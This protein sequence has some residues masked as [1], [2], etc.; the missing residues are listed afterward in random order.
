MNGIEFKIFVSPA[1]YDLLC[2]EAF[3]IFKR[4]LN[5][6]CIFTHT[7]KDVPKY[8][9]IWFFTFVEFYISLLLHKFDDVLFYILEDVHLD[10]KSIHSSYICKSSVCLK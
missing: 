1:S 9:N 4:M 3:A 10:L 5:Y 6:T 8:K 7:F 2:R